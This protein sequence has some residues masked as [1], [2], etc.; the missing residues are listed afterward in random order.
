MADRSGS[1]SSTS[2]SADSVVVGR[3][4]RAHGL[5]G[6]VG[7]EL[8]TDEPERRFAIGAEVFLADR[9]ALTVAD[10]RW[11]SGRLLVAFADQVDRTAAEALRGE[12]LYVPVRGDDTPTGEDEYYD[13]QLEGLQVV[14]G[15]GFGLGAVRAVI[16]LPGQDLLAVTRPDAPEVLVPFV[17]A[18]VSRVDLVAGIVTID[19][20]PGLFDPDEAE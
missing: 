12:Y 17:S 11:H 10:A 1:T 13:R 20:P 9:R 5:R 19:A 6:D 2:A 8:F 15:A 18:I 7:V 14:D 16:H 3:V 4:G